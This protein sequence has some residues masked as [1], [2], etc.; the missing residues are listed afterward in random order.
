MRQY[1][2]LVRVK[3]EGR[4]IGIISLN[5]PSLWYIDLVSVYEEG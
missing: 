1:N 3:V 5:E 4:E 2:L